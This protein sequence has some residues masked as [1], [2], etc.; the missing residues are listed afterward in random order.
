[1]YYDKK[2][3][4]YVPGTATAPTKPKKYNFKLP[5]DQF[6]K[7]YLRNDPSPQEFGQLAASGY[8]ASFGD[9]QLG[10]KAPA[11]SIR[12]ALDSIRAGQAPKR[13]TVNPNYVGNN[14]VEAQQ[15]PNP[16]ALDLNAY[17][18]RAGKFNLEKY[19]KQYGNPPG[20]DSVY[21]QFYKPDEVVSKRLGKYRK[22]AL[23]GREYE[24]DNSLRYQLLAL[25][26]QTGDPSIQAVAE[27]L[28]INMGGG[29]T[30]FSASDRKRAKSLL[31]EFGI[32]GL[33]AATIPKDLESR[34]SL[35]GSSGKPDNRSMNAVERLGEFVNNPVGPLSAKQSDDSPNPISFMENIGKSAIR[36]TLGL[37]VGL[38]Y[39]ATNPVETAKAIGE[40]YKQRYGAPFGVE[41]S[42]FLESSYEDPLAPVLDVLSIIPVLG[43][44]AKG[45]QVAKV[46]SVTSRLDAAGVAASKM[47]PPKWEGPWK[48]VSGDIGYN[49][50]LKVINEQL[51]GKS[52]RGSMSSWQYAKFIRQA[53][54]GNPQAAALLAV[55]APEGL[56]GMNSA[57]VPGAMD[58]AA[59]LF[60]ARPV[61]QKLAGVMP[62]DGASEAAGA[63][64]RALRAEEG[65]ESSNPALSEVSFRQTGSPIARGAQQLFLKSQQAIARRANDPNSAVPARLATTPVL[66][67]NWRYERALTTH[68][69]SVKDQVQRVLYEDKAF[70]DAIMSYGL[71]E[72][73][74]LAL[75][76]TVH[77]YAADPSV[78]LKIAIRRIEEQEAKGVQSTEASLQNIRATRELLSDEAFLSQWANARRAMT[79]LDENGVPKTQRGRDLVEAQR[80][81]S[82]KR[83]RVRNLIRAETDNAATISALTLR[84]QPIMNAFGL[85]EASLL[86]ELGDDL[87]SMG[88]INANWHLWESRGIRDFESEGRLFDPDNFDSVAE[89]RL[90]EEL[91]RSRKLLQS[92]TSTRTAG[93]TPLVRIDDEFQLNGKDYV[94]FRRVRLE[95]EFGEGGDDITRAALLDDTPLVAPKEVFVPTKSGAKR[96]TKDEALEELNVA[97][98]NALNKLYPNV[99]DYVDKVGKDTY[100]GRETFKQ[101][102]N[103]NEVA[104]SGIMNLR[105][106]VQFAAHRASIINRMG[107]VE[108]V[109]E[110]SAMAIPIESFD[111]KIHQKLRSIRIFDSAEEAQNYAD[112]WRAVKAQEKGTV[113]ETVAPNGSPVFAVRMKF[114]DENAA[115]LKEARTQDVLSS[116]EWARAYL[117]DAPLGDTP[118]RIIMVVPKSTVKK[119]RESYKRSDSLAT[120]TLRGL[121]DYFKILALSLSP[122]FVTQQVIGSTTMLMM[123]HP[124]QAP[125]I[126]ARAMQYGARNARRRNNPTRMFTDQADDL[127]I[128]MNRIVRDGSDNI[129]FEDS[130][131]GHLSTLGRYGE[132]VANIGYTIA[133]AF[134]FNMRASMIKQSALEYPGF[135]DF[136][137][138]DVVKARAAEGIPEMGYPR[139]SE[140]HAAFDLKTDPRSPYY[141]SN[142]MREARHTSD[143]VMGNYRDFSNAERNVRNFLFPFY[144]WTR[145]SAMFTKRLVQE[146]PLTANTLANIGNYGYEQVLE[147]GGLPDWLLES[148]P[149]PE[150]VESI[151]GLDPE[152]DN[153]LGFTSISP[154]GTL[155]RLV[156]NTGEAIGGD[157]G[158]AAEGFL[159]DASPFVQSVVE[160][161]TGRSILTGAPIENTTGILNPRTYVESFAEFPAMKNTINLFKSQSSL[162]ELAG[163]SDPHDIFRDPYD[164]DSK[165]R[166]P[167]E[168]LTEKFS[169]AS[170]PGLYN[171][172][173]PFRAHSMNPAALGKAIE[174]EYKERGVVFEKAQKEREKGA[175][176]VV[177][178]L[179]K[180]KAKRDFVYNVWMPAYGDSNPELVERVLRQLQKEYPKIPAYFSPSVARQITNG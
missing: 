8:V 179:E 62:V 119:L 125:M 138:S 55:A 105:M 15:M 58:R 100:M 122:R 121:T 109:L 45:A 14:V 63:V 95:G 162:N 113:I 82:L 117:D 56:G 35:G 66:G 127:D 159:S 79:D 84:Y 169:T 103:R 128:I 54:A 97:S 19:I 86:A 89:K 102:K 108:S 163:F 91:E 65:S 70:E 160:Q 157:L 92:D 27:G 38:Y 16:T 28:P 21:Y 49:A 120:K 156:Q 126:M 73:E 74:Q 161:T 4:R 85:D 170:V 175:Q 173:V 152:K 143:M 167:G 158:G 98:I 83:E 43:W 107:D 25:G 48:P 30:K 33:G 123:A 11:Y 68:E 26:R 47:R 64:N 37:P 34:Y 71:N 149:M 75:M 177:T 116:D 180:W 166:I 110:D 118:D 150:R 112:G 52:S 141:D 131:K 42:N 61:L 5:I 6:N 155:G 51:K 69:N 94:R 59:A 151:L 50:G 3:K 176:A 13:Y 132:D 142:V 18:K 7:K 178:R 9:G 129:F 17:M 124:M 104:Q 111:P 144:A 174:R 78:L 140:F 139:V 90:A 171:A 146:N 135:K 2:T 136:M 72:P 96:L 145:H 39:M 60:Q 153:R 31:A 172:F 40:D 106:D 32:G 46:A 76:S 36:M 137:K 147:T 115:A 44:A 23:E 99:R 20:P 101:R 165:L 93:G 134:E 22:K 41:D 24:S 1:L 88:L 77:G 87:G 164:P 114:F 148:I 133:R 57:Y 10:F 53:E 12:A 168:K 130:V 81:Y 29:D 80:L 154:V 67:Y